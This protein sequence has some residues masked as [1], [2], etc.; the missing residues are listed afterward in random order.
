MYLIRINYKN[1]NRIDE[2]MQM[3]ETIM[4]LHEANNN[5]PHFSQKE[6]EIKNQFVILNENQDLIG[7]TN[8]C[9]M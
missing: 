7:L 4:Q 3:V 5:N 2:I 1:L 8:I 9:N 6:K